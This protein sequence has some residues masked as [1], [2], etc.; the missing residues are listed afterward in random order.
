LIVRRSRSSL[1]P[2]PIHRHPHGTSYGGKILPYK[3][4]ALTDC[5]TGAY[6]HLVH[7]CFH[8]DT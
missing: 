3:Y 2:I 8:A 7:V 4:S 1:G 5:A 6:L